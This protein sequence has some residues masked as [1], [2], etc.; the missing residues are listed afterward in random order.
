M[1]ARFRQILVFVLVGVMLAIAMP[2]SAFAG[3]SSY[4]IVWGPNVVP[5]P[6]GGGGGGHP[7][8]GGSSSGGGAG[9][10][11]DGDA[12]GSLYGVMVYAPNKYAAAMLVCGVA[13][14]DSRIDHDKRMALS[15]E[16]LGGDFYTFAQRFSTISDGSGSFNVPDF[17]GNAYKNENMLWGVC[18]TYS[19]LYKAVN[20]YK[21]LYNNTQLQNAKSKL[22]DI[23]DGNDESGGDEP[24]V[25]PE[26]G[27]YI[28]LCTCESIPYS[29]AS[30]RV[31]EFTVNNNGNIV[32][33]QNVGTANSVN[34]PNVQYVDFYIN[35]T[36]YE[37]LDI[38]EHEFMC[39]INNNYLQIFQYETVEKTVSTTGYTYKI[40]NSRIIQ[41]SNSSMY[42]DN[43]GRYCV[44]MNSAVIPVFSSKTTNS[45]S[46]GWA[47]DHDLGNTDGGGGS[48]GSGGS[49]DTPDGDWPDD[50]PVVTP[51]P[52]ELPTPRDPTIPIQPQDPTVVDTPAPQLPDPTDPTIPVV[53]NPVDDDNFTADLQGVI[54]AMNEH[55]IHLQQR[56]GI[57]GDYVTSCFQVSIN[58]LISA[59][60]TAFATYAG[61]LVT[62]MHTEH[63]ADRTT[64]SNQV[65]WL[66]DDV[67]ENFDVL[68]EYLDDL[69]GFLDEKLDF[70]FTE[71]N[72][73]SLMGWLEKIYMKLGSG[74]DTTPVDPVSEPDGSGDWL[75][76]FL[77]SF[78]GALLGSLASVLT[79][80][81]ATMATLATKFPFSIPWDIM[82]ILGM[83]VA[84]PVCP[85][86]E[87]PCYSLTANGLSQVGSYEI[88]LEDIEFAVEGIR[89]ML[90][91]GFILLLLSRTKDFI[92]L[93]EGVIG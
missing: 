35:S 48:G 73:D 6:S 33:G 2:S 77:A 22:N 46:E 84:T 72:D 66:V 31:Y 8:D 83:L 54:D 50:D 87:I 12:S 91:I 81:T 40:Y 45:K 69:W 17:Y 23:L 5:G 9:T 88:N 19:K 7:I 3:E 20:I 41:Y 61:N 13:W 52:P 18:S 47:F 70:S 29:N 28:Y 21:A 24:S 51:T 78:F 85:D 75:S 79:D 25:E 80:A 10:T 42:I 67:N 58:D 39:F 43:N 32:A 59:M 30:R 15:N 4:R 92:E 34:T 60:N 76:Q 26:I 89:W 44:F 27:N 11:F 56:M 64:I 63:D 71:Y 36:F 62:N 16:S 55:C 53:G 68:M 14:N 1:C 37:S 90:R 93:I 86:V 82:A 65:A 74:I 49:G 38:D 57:V